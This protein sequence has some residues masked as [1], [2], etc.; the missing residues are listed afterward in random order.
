MNKTYIITRHCLALILSVVVIYL[1]ILILKNPDKPCF[2]L[3][4][5]SAQKVDSFFQQIKKNP[6]VLYP[7][8]IEEIN[9]YLE[10]LNSRAGEGFGSIVSFSNRKS[11]ITY[12]FPVIRRCIGWTEY[13]SRSGEE[14]VWNTTSC[15]Q[16]KNTTFIFSGA[17]GAGEGQAE[18]FLSEN[19]ILIFNTGGNGHRKIWKNQNYELRF[20]PLKKINP[21]ILSESGIFCLTVPKSD[22]QPGKALKIKVKGK[23][24]HGHWHKWSYFTLYNF[25]DNLKLLRQPEI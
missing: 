21:Q 19:P 3:L 20:F 14:V 5:F 4:K 16:K 6:P 22:I 13:N 9:S 25:S 1:F 15:E 7:S 2:P 12:R 24:A 23:E 18:I 17:L 11:C 8:Q 10:S